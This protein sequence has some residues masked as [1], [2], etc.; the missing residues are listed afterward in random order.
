MDHHYSFE[1]RE[2]NQFENRDERIQSVKLKFEVLEP[3]LPLF[4]HIG[5]LGQLYL[6]IQHI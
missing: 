3:T 1:G 4:S 6:A 2:T 5:T